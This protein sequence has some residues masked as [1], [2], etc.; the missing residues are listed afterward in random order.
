MFQKGVAFTLKGNLQGSIGLC[1]WA[2]INHIPSD[3]RQTLSNQSGNT[4]VSLMTSGCQM[5]A[6]W[7]QTGLEACLKNR[8]LW[9]F[10]G[11]N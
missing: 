8:S 11:S 2:F 7:L 6:R 9:H 1:A 3:Y 5:V 10:L 4:H